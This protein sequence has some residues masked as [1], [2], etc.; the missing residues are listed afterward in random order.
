L[1]IIVSTFFVAKLIHISFTVDVT[2]KNISSLLERC[3][4]KE[5]TDCRSSIKIIKM[6]D[7][8][9]VPIDKGWAWIVATGKYMKLNIIKPLPH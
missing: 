5:K 2:L 6:P 7:N 8:E 9:G 4:R 3:P 1:N